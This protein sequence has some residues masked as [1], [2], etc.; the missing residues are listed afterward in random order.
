MPQT[1]VISADQLPRQSVDYLDDG[2]TKDLLNDIGF[3]Y[4]IRQILRIHEGGLAFFAVPCNSYGF[5]SR[6]LHGTTPDEPFGRFC[7]TFVQQG[8]ILGARSCLLVMLCIARG[9]RFMFEN[10]DRSALGYF[11]Y[12]M[13]IMSFNQLKPERVFW[14]EPQPRRN[15]L[16]E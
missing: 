3:M 1:I 10:P 16:N 14:W 12:L 8:N 7:W 6:S 13:H 9:I 2:C 5:M 4:C 15:V 11:P